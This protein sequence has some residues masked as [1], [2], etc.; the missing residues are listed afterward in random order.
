MKRYEPTTPSP[1]AGDAHIRT[2]ANGNPRWHYYD[3]NEWQTTPMTQQESA[4]ITAA[5]SV[6]QSHWQTRHE[7]NMAMVP[8]PNWLRLLDALEELRRTQENAR[9]QETTR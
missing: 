6:M 5:R 9:E 7:W 1:Q 2:D 8:L 3:G 4:V